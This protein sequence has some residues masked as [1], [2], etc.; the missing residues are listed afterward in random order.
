MKK[1]VLPLLLVLSL[2]LTAFIGSNPVE[3]IQRATSYVLRSSLYDSVT[4]EP[5]FLLKSVST[6]NAT[7]AILVRRANGGVFSIAQSVLS[8]S[9]IQNQG[10]TTQTAQFAID[11]DG[12]LRNLTG[13]STIQSAIRAQIT[14]GNEAISLISATNLQRLYI[15]SAGTTNPQVHLDNVGFALGY[16]GLDFKFGSTITATISKNAPA[17][18]ND[19]I[20]FQYMAK[21]MRS[22][23]SGT[24]AATTISVAH[25]LSGITSSN[26]VIASPNSAAAA[27]YN[28]V[29]ID[30]TNVNFY[31]TVA[32]ISGTNNLIYSITIK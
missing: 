26:A 16:S 7:D 17:N 31:Y 14:G 19:V 30:A 25:G 22:T 2:A 8:N 28:Y 23:A 32:P 1:L 10:L 3:V 18:P 15:T 12:K 29:D 13:T 11:G 9:F 5:K 6:G 27:G 20:T 21:T 24:G 4:V